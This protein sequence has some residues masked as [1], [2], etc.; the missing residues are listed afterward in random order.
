VSEEQANQIITDKYGFLKQF[1]KD[2]RALL[3]GGS[4]FFTLVNRRPADLDIT[5]KRNTAT[6]FI[7]MRNRDSNSRVLIVGRYS[8][9]SKIYCFGRC[10]HIHYNKDINYFFEMRRALF[11]DGDKLISRLPVQKVID[12][13]VADEIVITTK[14]NEVVTNPLMTRIKI[15]IENKKKSN[16]DSNTATK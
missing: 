6:K 16:H 5:M 15:E 2:N 4:I 13:I 11:W 12:S 9:E 1:L 3:M 10:L 14:Y 7:R 8:R